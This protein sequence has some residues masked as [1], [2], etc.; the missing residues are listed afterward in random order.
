GS[1]SGVDLT[2]LSE[3]L[4]PPVFVR[5]SKIHAHQFRLSFSEPIKVDR[6]LHVTVKDS[7]SGDTLQVFGSELQADDKTRLLV[8]TAEQSEVRYQGEVLGGVQDTS[9]NK[10]DTV[11][12]VY[13]GS[14]KEDTVT[15]RLIKHDPRAGAV[16]QPFDLEIALETSQPLEPSTL[17]SAITLTDKDSI[18]V[19]GNWKETEGTFPRFKPET[20][21]QRDGEYQLVIETEKLKSYRGT[22][23]GDTTIV[24]PFKTWKH[25]ELGEI[26]GTITMFR[27]SSSI[28]LDLIPFSSQKRS[29][30]IVAPLKPYL[31]ENVPEGKYRMVVRIDEN[32]NGK[33]DA[34][35]SLPFEFAEPFLFFPDTIKVRKRWTTEGISIQVR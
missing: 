17:I 22:V 1:V 35:K 19:N 24:V 21:L 10:L 15:A 9:G 33:W 3:D 11:N 12:F 13:T 14:A 26:S 18:S 23:L 32:G 16:K 8:Y 25:E 7:I 4:E 30:H 29:R 27:D 28:L 2:L 34:G 6:P 20:L 31:L 5:A